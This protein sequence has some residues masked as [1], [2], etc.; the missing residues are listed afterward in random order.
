[1]PCL[2]AAATGTE[3]QKLRLKEFRGTPPKA[4][5]TRDKTEILNF[6]TEN[7]SASKGTIKKVKRQPMKWEN[8]IYTYDEELVAIIHKELYILTNGQ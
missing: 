1:M 4:G 8:Y 3:S 7:F 5:T 2:L 6:K